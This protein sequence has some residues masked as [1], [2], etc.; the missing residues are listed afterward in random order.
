MRKR[1]SFL[2]LAVWFSSLPSFALPARASEA[3]TASELQA[4]TIEGEQYASVNQT[5]V[6]KSERDAL[7]GA[8]TE[9]SNNDFLFFKSA[10]G[11]TLPSSGYIAEYEVNVTVPGTYGLDIVA[12]PVGMG[13]VS[14]YQIRINDGEY[15]DVNASTAVK[16]GQV[17]SPTNLFYKYKMTPVTLHQGTNTISFRILNGRQQDGRLYFFLDVMKLTKQPWGVHG[18][19]ANAANHLFQEADDKQATVVFTDASSQGHV[20]DYAIEDY[21]GNEVVRERVAFDEN[22]P[23]YTFALPQL[24]RGHYTIT[25]EADENGQPIHDYVSI[26]MNRSERRAVADSPFAMD[27]AGG[28]LFPAADAPNYARAVWL[29]GVDYVRERMHWNSIESVPGTMTFDKYDPYNEAYGDYGIRVLE[30]NH[31]APAWAKDP[32]KSLP[33]NLLDAYAWAKASV[34]HNG[35]QSDWEFW[36]E[37]DIGYSADSE[38]AD[39]YAAFLK[40]TTIAARDA[41]VPTRVALAGIAYPPGNYVEQ[42]MQN[43]IAGY[44]DMYNFHGHRNDNDGSRVLSTPPTFAVNAKFIADYGLDDKPI[45]VTEAGVSLKFASGSQSLTAEQL[46][47]Q[48]RYLTTSTIESIAMGVD[49]HFWFVFPHYLENGM[50]WGSFSSQGAP[51]AAINAEA[52]MTHALGEA[53]YRGRLDG[54]PAGVSG[55]VFKDG[56]DSV[57]AFW[58]ENDTPLTVRAGSGT[59]LLT[60]IMGREQ[61]VASASGDYELSAGPDIRYL[62][63]PGDFPGLTE[64]AYDAPTPQAPELSAAE[65]VVLA[66][67]YPEATA[68]KAKTKGYALDKSA[69]T[70]VKVDVYNFN[71]SPM[72]GT[73]AG[74]TYGGWS[75]SVPSQ[76]ATIA[77]YSKTTLTFGLT[78]GPNVM[79]DVAFPVVFQGTF[80]GDK[81]SKSVTMVASDENPPATPSALVPE[82]DDPARWSTNL[83]AGST[84]TVTSP[85][86]GEIQFDYAFGSGDK[87]TYPRFELPEGAMFADT[88]GLTFEVYFETPVDGVVVRS[89]MYEQNGAEYFTSAG[90]APTGGWQSVKIPWSDFAAFGTPDDNF[91]LDPDQIR[92]ISIGI[93]SRT[94][95]QVSYKIRNIGP[96]VQPDSGLYSKFANVTPASGEPVTAGTVAI[97]A[98][99]QQGEIPVESG[100]MQVKADGIPAQ[101]QWDGQTVTA[102]V[103]LAAGSHELEVKAFDATGRLVSKRWR[104]DV[105]S[106]P[107]AADLLS[108]ALAYVGDRLPENARAPLADKLEHARDAWNRG[109]VKEAVNQLRAFANHAKA[110]R[111]KKL[112]LEQADRLTRLAEAV[113]QAIRAE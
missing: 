16:T 41:G 87:W 12:S 79:A 18:I 74:T 51:Y 104:I 8:S 56:T 78:G 106:A 82:Y 108:E 70:E 102:T 37:P 72:T 90:I 67:Q 30:L 77:P 103:Q 55:Y 43:D 73:I 46:R 63:I 22:V 86:P 76:Q 34:V 29:T 33:R 66:Q 9:L 5:P 47:T 93:N 19:E 27:V 53:E 44:I 100:S 1:L 105:A 88:E 45:Y 111:G 14:P 59:A 61:Q 62:R 21:F 69:T 15:Y 49:K 26:V 98:Q 32:G 50:S 64:A 71:A 4:I 68:S 31:I 94:A 113:E 36:N 3:G 97:T 17:Q 95:T 35:S 28:S 60:D 13:H 2:A 25:A 10:A 23:S 83:S 42:L 101:H 54:V 110:Q 40:A 112:T 38:P 24:P 92:K 6:A 65:R 85:A 89:F 7:R 96:Y 75:L 80:D 11:A 91:H 39:R 20:L 84:G 58:S 81:T 109:N 48:A 52:A 107:S 99:L 57:A